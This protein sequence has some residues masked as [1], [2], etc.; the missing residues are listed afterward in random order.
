MLRMVM[1]DGQERTYEDV[2]RV[3]FKPYGVHFFN[4]ETGLDTTVTFDKFKA[5][6]F[7]MAVSEG[8]VEHA[9]RCI[10]SKIRS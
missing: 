4:P 9:R 10:D 6:D 8:D 7:K 5:I 1:N 2:Q 3:S